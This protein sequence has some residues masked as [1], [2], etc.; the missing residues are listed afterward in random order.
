MYRDASQGGQAGTPGGGQG[1]TTG[2][3]TGPK[4]GEVVDADFEDLGEKK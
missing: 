4:E 2:P 3:V 1:P